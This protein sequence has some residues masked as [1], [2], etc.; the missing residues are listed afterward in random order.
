MIEKIHTSAVGILCLFFALPLFASQEVNPLPL[1]SA[2]CYGKL[3]NGLTYYI[4]QNAQPEQ[5]AEFYLVQATGS[6]QEDDNQR[7]LAHVLEHMA[8]NGSECFPE[9]E[10][11]S[12]LERIGLKNGENL[13]AYTAF[14]ETVYTI[15]NAPTFRSGIIDSC[16]LI[17]RD[18]SSNLLLN[19]E[20][21]EK[22]RAVIREEWRTLRD[23]NYRLSEQQYPVLLA[24]SRYA[25]RLPIG[26]IEVIESFKPD[27]LKAYYKKWYRPDM[28]A[29]IVVGDLDTAY[30]KS[31]LTELFGAIPKPV[32]E[33]ERIYASV[34][35]NEQ[36]RVCI[37]KDKESPGYIVNL[38]YKHDKMP[39]ELYASVLGLR[40]DYLQTVA[41]T[42]LNERLDLLLYEADPP[43]IFGESSIG[44]YMGTR[45]KAAWS[46]AAIAEEGKVESTLGVLA[47]EAERVKRHG[48][49]NPEYERVKVN[50]LKYYETLYLER[51]N[52][53]SSTYA[54]AYVNHFTMGGYLPDM[55][56]E[57]AWVNQI[58]ETTTLDD[59]NRYARE[60]LDTR[61]VII[62]IT[63]P[64]KDGPGLYP[65]E[66]ALVDIFNQ[67]TEVE[68]DSYEE[69]EN[70]RPLLG[71]QPI[72]GEIIQIDQDT[73][74][75]ATILKLSNG[76]RVVAK[77]TAF[78]EDEVVVSGTSPG[79]KTLFDEKDLH[80]QKVLMDVVSIGG[81]GE[82]TAVELNRI[83]A[84]KQVTCTA[85]IDDNS[86]TVGG[87]SSSSDLR[88]LFE[89]I[90]LHF[91]A[92]R[93]DAEAFSSY[94]S[95]LNA[96]L[97]NLELNPMVAFSDTLTTAL[98]G[99]NPKVKRIT[100]E[101]IA[102]LD[103]ARILE[104]YKER[105][106]DASDFVFTVVGNFNMDSLQLFAKEY[107]ASLPVQH[108]VEKGNEQALVP[109]K[110]GVKSIHFK[111]VMET[112]KATAV[113]FYHGHT[114]YTL[115]NILTA[116]ILTQLLDLIYMEKIRKDEGG[117]YGVSSL[118]QLTAFPNGQTSLQIYYDTDPQK[119]E[120]INKLILAELQNLAENNPKS[121]H[122]AKIKENIVKNFQENQTS[123]LYWLS[124][125][126][127]YY[128]SGLNAYT[129]Y[130]ATLAGIT[131]EHIRNFT[132]ALVS[133]GNHVEVIL[134]PE[135]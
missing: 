14:D 18:I 35:D 2:I 113:H 97:K 107:L 124:L 10:I 19:D 74:F 16:L 108:R 99:N 78:R 21:I 55:E 86:E 116:N 1:D 71:V 110:K 50:V 130:L 82:H 96:Q 25:E 15:M 91:M 22:E 32:G 115:K 118:A 7:G 89:L 34:P 37:A 127:N 4:R 73:V 46:V 45:T 36:P 77:K 65:A 57:F 106:E 109:L 23:A 33:V 67:S 54:N 135:E 114:D 80:N 131:P 129:D 31:K 6:L 28:Q 102:A 27:D 126:D 76:V 98:Y 100:K 81:L 90:Y 128:F 64:D 47:R 60:V 24:G 87:Y 101:E 121:E 72:P 17:L 13:N 104:M 83:L 70:S 133:S 111:K 9:Q 88:T 93:M 52:E 134:T 48:F 84:G 69:E 105:F 92:P 49:S 117:S 132:K 11:D 29:V 39:D 38:F 53:E 12:Y 51:N 120:Q 94:V 26:R 119:V 66:E 41:S 59:I 30:V 56:T 20:A 8:F 61:N 58:A 122:L 63:G 75:D 95:R 79:G 85:T 5:R 3:E 103:Y 62:S 43:F 123:N 42:L 40:Q 112:P 68:I 125:I 44:N